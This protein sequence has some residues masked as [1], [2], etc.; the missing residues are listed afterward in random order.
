MSKKDDIKI[1]GWA[2]S[3]EAISSRAEL[4]SPAKSKSKSVYDAV[5]ARRVITAADYE[6][7]KSIVPQSTYVVQDAD[8]EW[9]CK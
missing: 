1:M 6:H 5:A 9:A 4:K 3:V 8:D 7:L 2:T